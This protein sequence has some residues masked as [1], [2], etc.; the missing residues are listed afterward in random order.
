MA[1]PISPKRPAWFCSQCARGVANVTP[2]LAGMLGWC[3]HG[4]QDPYATPK[5]V[6]VV[7]TE[8]EAD[9]L[10]E[11]KL[12]RQALRRAL[13]KGHTEEGRKT[14]S[15]REARLLAEHDAQAR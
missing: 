13:E 2:G 3:L 10:R 4:S 8:E 15:A 1:A 9:R 12:D 6:A 11:A 7:D 5:L 14:L